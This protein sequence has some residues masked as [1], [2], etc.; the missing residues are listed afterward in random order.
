MMFWLSYDMLVLISPV[1]G[2]DYVLA[3]SLNN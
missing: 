2:T 1:V 3:M